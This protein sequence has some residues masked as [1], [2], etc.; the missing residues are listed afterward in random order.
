METKKCGKCQIEKAV[1]E[2]YIRKD[3][4][5]GYRM[6]CK[7]CLLE[8]HKEKYLKNR[9]TKL[10][11]A[12]DYYYFNKEKV[13][14]YQ[15][16]NKEK[17][18]EKTK[19]YRQENKEKIK[20]KVKKYRENNKEKYLEYKKSYC[21]NNKEKIRTYMRSYNKERTNNDTQYRLITNIRSRI[22]QF[23]KSKNITKRSKTFEI[24]G[25]TPDFLKEYLEKQFTK[26]MSWEL[27]GNRI[28]ID[29]IIPLS[30]AKTEEETYMLCHYTNLQPLWAEDN[31]KKSN[32]IV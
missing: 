28:H 23:L 2:F 15:Q 30:S 3:T 12:K 31:L 19:K 22:R 18:K 1:F 16:E 8:G 7:K 10:E 11:Y 14:E 27:L 25:C 32:K 21:T 20:E 6:D 4:P 29:H 9:N 24:V 17:I 13:R 26:G 5:D